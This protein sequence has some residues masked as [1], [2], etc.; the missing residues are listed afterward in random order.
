MTEKTQLVNK[1]KNGTVIDH[2]PVNRGLKVLELLGSNMSKIETAVVII[3]MVS[4]TLDHKDIL[5]IEN[6]ELTNNEVNNISLIAPD[7]TLNIIRDWKVS[8]KSDITVPDILEDVFDCPNSNCISNAN[9]PNVSKFNITNKNPLSLTC[10]YCERIF[11]INE[12]PSF[13]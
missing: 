10:Q 13:T 8:H 7:A 4:G 2:I 11:S 3:N 9:E 12:L 1:I 6:R 5:K